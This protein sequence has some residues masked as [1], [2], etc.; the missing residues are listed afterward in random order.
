MHT[1]QQWCQ[2]VNLQQLQQH[3]MLQAVHHV[4]ATTMRCRSC[5]RLQGLPPCPEGSAELM[6]QPLQLR[7]SCCSKNV[8]PRW[9]AGVNEVWTGG[10]ECWNTCKGSNDW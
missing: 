9:L 2:Q 1:L 8:H 4:P 7:L 6:R 5:W 3:T 10:D